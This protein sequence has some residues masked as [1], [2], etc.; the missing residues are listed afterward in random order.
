MSNTT[1]EDIVMMAINEKKDPT[2]EE[3]ESFKSLVKDWFKFDDQIRK[4][5]IAIRERKVYQKELDKQMQNFMIK[6]GYNDLNTSHGRIKSNVREVKAPIKMK[7]IKDQ[8]C[9]NKDMTGPELYEKI[10]N[11]DRQ[12]YVK[13]SLRRIVPKVSLRL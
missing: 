7:E 12:T 1:T 8:L 5:M 10:F 9:N 4:L 3:L 2:E 6:F 11:T 13:S